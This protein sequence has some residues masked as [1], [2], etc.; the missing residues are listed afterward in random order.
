VP[1]VLSGTQLQ[2][3]ADAAHGF[4]AADLVALVTEASMAALRR[5]VAQRARSGTSA[6]S[7][8]EGNGK[9]PTLGSPGGGSPAAA[10]SP[11]AQITWHDFQA[12]RARVKPSALRSLAVELPRVSWEDIGGLQDVKQRCGCLK[13]AALV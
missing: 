3:L 2:Q 5:L 12:A 1:H 6:D 13:S 4:V 11:A 9:G 7:S 10:G 8:C